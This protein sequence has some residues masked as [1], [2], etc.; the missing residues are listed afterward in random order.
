[1]L[2][3]S[4]WFHQQQPCHISFILYI[5]TIS[6]CLDYLS[7]LP[8]LC[9]LFARFASF[10]QPLKKHNIDTTG[11][12]RIASAKVRRGGGGGNRA[13]L[14]SPHNATALQALGNPFAN[15][16]N[17][18]DGQN[19]NMSSSGFGQ[20]QGQQQSAF[21]FGSSQS[22]PPVNNN[23]TFGSQT[24]QN[25]SF[26]PPPSTPQT[27]SQP[28]NNLFGSVAAP[29]GVFAFTAT[30]NNPFSKSSAPSQ[31]SF[32]N[33]VFGSPAG[34]NNTFDGFGEPNASNMQQQQFQTSPGNDSMQISP[35][36]TPLKG[37]GSTPARPSIFS[38]MTAESQTQ[39]TPNFFGQLQ[40]QT[41]QLSSFHSVSHEPSAAS[42]HL[43]KR[44][45]IVPTLG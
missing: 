7:P 43:A 11:A 20:Q 27:S 31:P 22:F 16:V 15:P 13:N 26:P 18:T 40:K 25:A 32:S 36:A 41:P 30:P 39:P 38:T 5:A 35:P 21:N 23:I 1:M 8:T 42:V 12:N 6:T 45:P 29:S 19:S 10:P 24:P 2:P 34:N 17:G 44:F 37:T 4:N 28:G 3:P 14:F 9:I 33:S